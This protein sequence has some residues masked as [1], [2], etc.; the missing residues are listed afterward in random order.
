MKLEANA[1]PFPHLS[2]PRKQLYSVISRVRWIPFIK[3]V[4]PHIPLLTTG[5]KPQPYRKGDASCLTLTLGLFPSLSL[6]SIGNKSIFAKRY[7][8]VKMENTTR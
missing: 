3:V 5:T 8:T 4:S 7:I 6:C 1:K 2:N